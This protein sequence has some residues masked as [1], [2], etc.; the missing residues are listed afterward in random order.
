VALIAE[1]PKMNIRCALVAGLLGFPLLAGSALAGETARLSLAE[2]ARLGD[3]AAVRSLLE[4]GAKADLAGPEGSAALIWAATRNDLEMV[5]LLLRAGADVKAANEY[6]ATALYAAAASPDAAMTEKLLAA[7]ADPNAH[8]ISGETAL[9]EA[10]RRGNLATVQALLKAGADPNVQEVNG[11]QSAVMWAAAQRHGAVTKELVEH[12]AD[13]SARSKTGFTALMFAGQQGDA[14]SAA[15]L[16]AAGANPND[17]AKSTGLTALLVASAMGHPKVAALLLDKGAN[18]DAVAGDGFSSLHYAAHR[19]GAAAVAI[20][21]ALLAHH[22]NPNIQLNQPKR[23]AISPNGVMFQGATPVSFAAEV[24]NVEAVKALVGAGADPLI[25][26]ELGTTPLMMAAGAATDTSRPRPA[27]ERA[28]A[29]ETVK[30]LVEHGADANGAGQ[31]GWTALHSA[32]YQGL[33][34]VVAYLASK[35]ANLEAQ[36]GFGQTPLSISYALVTKGLG[37]NYY[38]TARS[39]HRDT[40]ELLLKLG[41]TPIERSGVVVVTQRAGE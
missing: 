29:V 5:E 26:T 14:D 11:G 28:A 24:N 1:G 27:P 31:F 12:H 41:A 18:P 23:T 21:N 4:H 10:S 37:G 34:D 30:F 17:V 19:R 6:G 35:G 16:L 39:L 33:S 36:D 7:G 25:P 32:A 20:V 8:L 2:A 9:M 13:V 38:Q 15:A 3:R 22:A 40:A